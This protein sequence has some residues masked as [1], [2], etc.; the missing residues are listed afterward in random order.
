MKNGNSAHGWWW[1]DGIYSTSSGTTARP[2]LPPWTSYDAVLI[3]HRG[4]RKA[5]FLLSPAKPSRANHMPFHLGIAVIWAPLLLAPHEV[6]PRQP[7][8]IEH[9]P[10]QVSLFW[11]LL[12]CYMAEI[13]DSTSLEIT[14]SHLTPEECLVLISSSYTYYPGDLRWIISVFWLN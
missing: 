4:P 10:Y 6:K 7:C 2:S 5:S 13:H 9:S 8:S 11:L 1:P 12:L 3:R 14:L